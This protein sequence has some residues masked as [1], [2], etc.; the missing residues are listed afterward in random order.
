MLPLSCITYFISI[1]VQCLL[2]AGVFAL[3]DQV[4]FVV[5]LVVIFCLFVFLADYYFEGIQHV[6]L[7]GYLPV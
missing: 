6:T 7:E 5:F 1:S 2:F 4:E 3:P